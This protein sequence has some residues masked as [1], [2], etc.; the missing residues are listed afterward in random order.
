M[1]N[2]SNKKMRVCG[3]TLLEVIIILG[4]FLV[5]FV[6]ILEVFRVKLKAEEKYKSRIIA[7]YLARALMDEILTQAFGETAF[8]PDS[9]ETT[10]L[11]FD[12]TDDYHGYGTSGEE[13]PPLD[14]RGNPL[15]GTANLPNYSDF[16]RQVSVEYVNETMIS[17]GGPTDYKK[18]TVTATHPSIPDVILEG[19]KVNT[20]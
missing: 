2:D 16:C 8:G 11:D 12:D 3:F 5:F 20:P 15:D 7:A 17:S 9:G 6:G 13:C 4:I 14:M 10:R 18:V 1:W 19:I